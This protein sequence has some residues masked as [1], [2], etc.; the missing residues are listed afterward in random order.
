LVI[1]RPRNK[2][3][4][5]AGKHGPDGL[6]AAQPEWPIP[7]FQQAFSK[8]QKMQAACKRG[9]D[10]RRELAGIV[11]VLGCV[12]PAVPLVGKGR[13]ASRTSWGRL[14]Y[15]LGFRPAAAPKRGI[16]FVI[17]LTYAK[18]ESY[19]ESKKCFFA[20]GER[21]HHKTIIAPTGT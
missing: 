2:L 8:L 20:P 3:P 15:L 17:I 16:A 10:A 6:L 9:Q 4:S 1:C 18:R 13:G 21:F 7:D 14:N 19:G 5:K 12:G 11:V